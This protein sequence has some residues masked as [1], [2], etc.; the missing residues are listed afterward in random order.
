MGAAMYFGSTP[1]EEVR[2]YFEEL[3]AEGARLGAPSPGASL[4][5]A[6]LIAM[7]GDFETARSLVAEAAP[8]ARELGVVPTGMIGMAGGYVEE[9]AGDPEAAIELLR[10][11]WDVFGSMG[12]TGFR[13]TVGSMMAAALEEAGQDDEAARILDEVESF[14]APDD[15]DPQVRLRWVRALLLARRG[16][17]DD[18]ERLTREAVAIVD[19]TD[20]T[21][22]AADA[23]VAHATVLDAAGKQD[24]ARD[25]WQHAYD[26]YDQKGVRVRAQ[27]VR[28][29]LT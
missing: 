14:A 10:E 23:Y 20:Y 22:A 4:M 1:V 13:S 9:L 5:K 24:E 3:L 28:E 17:L 29:H 6:A 27:Q 21:E 25:A 11:P 8:V 15:F 19:E 12:E 7:G 16:Q 18:A 2:A 26:L